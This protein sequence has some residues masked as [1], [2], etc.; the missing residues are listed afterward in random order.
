MTVPTKSNTVTIVEQKGP[1]KGDFL[2]GTLAALEAVHGAVNTYAQGN[3]VYVVTRAIDIV[4]AIY[5]LAD[6]RTAPIDYVDIVGHGSAGHLSVGETSGVAGSKAVV[7][8]TAAPSKLAA[9]MGAVARLRAAPYHPGTIIRLVGCNTARPRLG[10][11]GSDGTVFL[12]AL[13]TMTGL[14]VM[15]T[16]DPV[17]PKD[18]D[19]GFFDAT[20]T[21]RNLRSCKA[22]ADQ[23]TSTY[24]PPVLSAISL[25]PPGQVFDPTDT[26]MPQGLA[27]AI[28]VGFVADASV[29]GKQLRV[30]AELYDMKKCVRLL[31]GPA[32]Y[33]L[34]GQ[35]SRED[36]TVAFARQ[37]DLMFIDYQDRRYAF[38]VR[39]DAIG[40]LTSIAATLRRMHFD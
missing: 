22:S 38:A 10:D 14:E 35:R 24:D 21:P 37:G 31:K 30:L 5:A 8:L 27:P 18:F 23:G 7:E 16:L 6:Q 33:L 36:V 3:S 15:G 25:L 28:L 13:A 17:E 11:S 39:D 2:E 9:I 19:G 40:L 20:K 12:H 34:A 29:D 4:K 32:P 26:G 1:E